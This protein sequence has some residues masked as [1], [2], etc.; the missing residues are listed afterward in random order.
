MNYLNFG[1]A[2][3]PVMVALVSGYPVQRYKFKSQLP[4][5][6]AVGTIGHGLE[7]G[8]IWTWG[9]GSSSYRNPS[10]P[11]EERELYT[12]PP[13]TE[14]TICA[15]R[16]PV[17]ASI[18]SGGA[19]RGTVYGDP[20]WVLP[21]FYNPRIEK[22]YELGVILHL[23]ELTSREYF[24]E[25]IPGYH[26]YDIGPAHTDAV[27]LISTVTPISA[28]ALKDKIDEIVSCK[29]IISTSLHGMVIA[30]SYGIP[31]VY[32]APNGEQRGLTTVA[33]DPDSSLDLRIVDLYQGLGFK[34]IPAYIQPRNQ[35]TDWDKVIEAVDQSWFPKTLDEAALLE[36][37]P[38]PRQPIAA[39]PGETVWDHPLIQG[40]TLQHSVTE[41]NQREKARIIELRKLERI[42]ARHAG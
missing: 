10:A 15:T 37:F 29:R 26:R 14:I 5:L 39:R 38:L 6:S 31:C 13:A 42:A 23:S 17:A 33:L 40:L 35:P 21:R 27:H 11:A 4:R 9:T 12:P 28:Y 1:D 41:I 22:K 8:H 19:T 7:G 16:G 24:V 32:F 2:L 3:S 36:A 25:Y 34:E 20:V 18:L 30:E